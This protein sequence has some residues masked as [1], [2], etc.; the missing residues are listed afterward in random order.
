MQ[1]AL[2]NALLGKEKISGRLPVSIP[3][4]AARGSGLDLE[5]VDDPIVKEKAEPGPEL[6]RVLP[7]SVGADVSLLSEL[8]ESAIADK[9]WPGG[10][11]LAAKDGQIFYHQGH[12]YHTYKNKYPVRSSDIFDL[13]SVTKVI[14]T[15]SAVMKLLEQG[16]LDLD[17][18]VVSISVYSI[19][20]S[21]VKITLVKVV[22]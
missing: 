4:L 12:G 20:C 19:P 22:S 17:K 11:L 1:F 6:I 9:G 5:K 18:T 15:T 16:K 14:A 3:G 7:S 8:M 13:A 2:A 10:V 21:R